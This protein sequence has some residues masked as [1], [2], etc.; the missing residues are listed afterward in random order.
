MWRAGGRAHVDDDLGGYALGALDAG[1]ARRVA[2]HLRRCGRCRAL[3]RDYE[4]ARDDLTLASPALTPPL[5]VWSAIEGRL[6]APA[7][8]RRHGRRLSL[9]GWLRPAWLTAAVALLL[10]GALLGW[11][12]QLQQR[13]GPSGA[14]IEQLARTPH[15]RIAT[16][17]GADSEGRASG[18]LYID[19]ND[20]DATAAIAVAGL[21]QL[22]AGTVYRLW[23]IQVDGRWASF[24][25]ITPDRYGRAVQIITLPGSVS[26]F[27][28]VAVTEEAAS[29]GDQPAGP[30]ILIGT[31]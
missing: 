7:S 10:A 16:L 28:G 31:F 11:N 26:T 30:P 13:A 19:A 8:A 9:R 23:L 2:A 5:A 24:G 14:L 3:L 6:N 20:E 22:S 15:G 12:I 4:S 18:R 17:I 21:P 25:R 1:D 27:V 29:A